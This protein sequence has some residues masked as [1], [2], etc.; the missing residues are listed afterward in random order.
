MQ[1]GTCFP[2][3]FGFSRESALNG[4]CLSSGAKPFATEKWWLYHASLFGSKSHWEPSTMRRI[5]VLWREL[6][7]S[8]TFRVVKCRMCRWCSRNCLMVT[9]NVLT[10]QHQ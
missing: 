8:R 10:V 9:V 7:G 2:A 6:Y 1:S 3:V 5:V 4:F